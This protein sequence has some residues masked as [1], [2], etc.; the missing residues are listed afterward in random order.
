MLRTMAATDLSHEARDPFPGGPLAVWSPQAADLARELS[1]RLQRWAEN[2]STD[3]MVHDGALQRIAP[4][5]FL[6][7]NAKPGLVDR[8]LLVGCAVGPA[9][10]SH[11]VV[12][13]ASAFW[14][15]TGQRTEQGPELMSRSHRTVIAGVRILHARFRPADLERIGGVPVTVPA[16]TALDLLR[17]TAA[18]LALPMVQ[19][20]L[21]QGHCELEQI[22]GLHEGVIGH[23]GAGRAGTLL[24]RWGTGSDRLGTEMPQVEPPAAVSA[25]TA[26][27]DPTGLP[28]AVTR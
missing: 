9:L 22:R 26:P 17:F 25:G 13:G 21:D 6:D 12:A 11:H 3:S 4:G 27:S 19:I 2:P 18:P 7:G 24:A 14:V 1:P 28:S 16:R 8:A 10:R 23:R 15:H 5:L 20:L